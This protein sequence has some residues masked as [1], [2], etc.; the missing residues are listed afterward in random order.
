[1]TFADER[2]LLQE[3][4]TRLLEANLGAIFRRQHIEQR[5]HIRFRISLQY[6]AQHLLGTAQRVEP[7]VDDSDAH[8]TST[9]E[10]TNVG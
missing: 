7:I 3:A 4:G 2:H 5:E 8:R 9:A 1:M 6:L 10:T